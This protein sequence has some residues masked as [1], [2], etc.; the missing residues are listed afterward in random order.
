MTAEELLELPG[1]GLRYELINGELKSMTP[2]GSEHGETVGWV[3]QV[4]GGYIAKGKLGRFVGAETGFLIA[5]AP[6]TVLAPDFAFISKARAVGRLPKGYFP[7]PPDLAVEV[8]SP[9]DRA[10]EVEDKIQRWLES[11]CG[12]VWVF[13]TQ[14]RTITVHS[15]GGRGV[16]LQGADVVSGGEV[17]P[18]FEAAVEA[19][20]P[21]RE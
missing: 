1:N 14:R 4:I 2:S 15:K 12:Q 16:V 17:L 18:G 9:H 5:R 7:G 19:L 11:G 10:V 8:L 20:F 6:D 3:C 21:E 13:N